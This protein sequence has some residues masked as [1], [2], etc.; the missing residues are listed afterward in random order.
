[1]IPRRRPAVRVDNGRRRNGIAHNRFSNPTSDRHSGEAAPRHFK[2]NQYLS[3]KSLA[4]DSLTKVGIGMSLSLRL[5]RKFI[6]QKGELPMMDK[7]N[8]VVT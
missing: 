3:N 2:H 6:R 5:S 4:S 1:M 8:A 7:G